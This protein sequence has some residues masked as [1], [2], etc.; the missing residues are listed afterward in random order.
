MKIGVLLPT[1]I[2]NGNNYMKFIP[3]YMKFP[4]LE[5]SNLSRSSEISPL[6]N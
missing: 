4:I 3:N 6:S 5:F 2:V 1:H